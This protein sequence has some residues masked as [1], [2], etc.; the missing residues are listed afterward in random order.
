MIALEQIGAY[1]PPSMEHLGEF[2]LIIFKKK[3]KRYDQE[4][5]RPTSEI[6]GQTT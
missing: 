5:T 4:D 1:L 3:S 2:S 6:N